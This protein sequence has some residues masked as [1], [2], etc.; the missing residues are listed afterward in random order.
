MALYQIQLCNGVSGKDWYAL[1][2]AQR[3]STRM[4][5]LFDAVAFAST[6]AMGTSSL[7]FVCPL[8]QSST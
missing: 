7:S 5:Q 8:F 2:A 4:N 1:V 3:W 6:T